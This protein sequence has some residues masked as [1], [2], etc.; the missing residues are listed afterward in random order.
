MTDARQLLDAYA[1]TGKH[2]SSFEDW[3][4]H[5]VPHEEFAPRVFAALHAVLDEHEW[6]NIGGVRGKWCKTCT[7]GPD[8]TAPAAWPCPTVQAI[9]TALE[10]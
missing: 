10:G 8:L 2:L 7:A 1:E 5:P 3:Q 9:I 6:V 4:D